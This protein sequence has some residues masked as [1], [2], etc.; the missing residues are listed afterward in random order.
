MDAKG[1][2][3]VSDVLGSIDRYLPTNSKRA[4]LYEYLRDVC[5]EQALQGSVIDR[6]EILSYATKWVDELQKK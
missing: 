1:D 5:L 2:K 3:I 4:E 6:E